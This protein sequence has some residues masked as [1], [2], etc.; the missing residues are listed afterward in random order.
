MT[1]TEEAILVVIA[2]AIG[3]TLYEERARIVPVIEKVAPSMIVP[4]SPR[5]SV[6]GILAPLFPSK[7]PDANFQEIT[8]GKFAPGFGSSCGFVPSYL[9]YMLGVTDCNILNRDTSDCQYIP[10][11]NISKI[12]N[13]GRALGV[14]VDDLS[15]TPKRG[16]V[17]FCSNGPPNTEHVF[18]IKDVV[19]DTWYSWDGGHP[20]ADAMSEA[21]RAFN[22]AQLQ[23]LGGPRTVK[24][25]VDLERLLAL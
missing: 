1:Q 8:G 12:Y 2:G 17:V 11:A 6:E 23:F 16:D 14:W 9:W 7:Y 22:G 18:V 25:W 15:Q 13:G 3:V 19:G 20:S 21:S 5:D 24:G 10:G 4:A